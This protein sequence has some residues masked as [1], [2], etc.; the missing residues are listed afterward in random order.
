MA[1][2]LRTLAVRELR[3]PTLRHGRDGLSGYAH[4]VDSLVPYDV[5]DDQPEKRDQCLGVAESVG[6]GQLSN[7]LDVSS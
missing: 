2:T 6:T 4:S 5:V 1:L 7:G 3:T